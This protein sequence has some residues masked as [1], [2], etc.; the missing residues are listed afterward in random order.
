M[1]STGGKDYLYLMDKSTKRDLLDGAEAAL[2]PEQ[3]AALME[4]VARGR[5]QLAAGEAISGEDVSRWL[6]S[7]GLETELPVPLMHSSS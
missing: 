3:R 2:T 1:A 7:W 4:S 6:R 5:A